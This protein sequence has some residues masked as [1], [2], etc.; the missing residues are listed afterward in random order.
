[1]DV[2]HIDSIAFY[3]HHGVPDEEQRIGHRYEVD[4][5]LR[6]DLLEAGRSDDLNRSVDYK[7]VAHR[8]AEIGTKEQFRLLEALAERIAEVLLSEFD[9]R[10]IRV[11]VRKLQPPFELIAAWVGVEIERGYEIPIASNS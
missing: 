8:I 2:I 1:M 3:A 5:S 11:R 4:V 6:L 9:L 7:L 10:S